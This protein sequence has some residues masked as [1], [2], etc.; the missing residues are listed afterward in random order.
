MLPLNPLQGAI[1]RGV[2]LSVLA[3]PVIIHDAPV[4][5]SVLRWHLWYD[6]GLIKSVP[7][8]ETICLTAIQEMDRLRSNG[9][10]VELVALENRLREVMVNVSSV[11]KL[12][13]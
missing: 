12:K 4:L 9:Y 13:N 11:E 5:T 1:R 3:N 6:Q 7:L 8:S 2:L 10:P